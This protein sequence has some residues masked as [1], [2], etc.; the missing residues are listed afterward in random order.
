MNVFISEYA[1]IIHKF[2]AQL[3]LSIKYHILFRWQLWN[4][5]LEGFWQLIM[6]IQF[7]KT[8]LTATISQSCCVVSLITKDL[9]NSWQIEAKMKFK[10]TTKIAQDLQLQRHC[11]RRV[12]MPFYFINVILHGHLSKILRYISCPSFNRTIY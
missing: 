7:N 10:M 4:K 8:E 12:H 3:I 6:F 9:N 1:K 11:T 5:S 2:H